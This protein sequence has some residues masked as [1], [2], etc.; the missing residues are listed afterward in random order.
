[1]MNQPDARC[2]SGYH[3]VRKIAIGLAG[4]K[5][6]VIL[7]FSVAYKVVV[8]LAGL[9][10]AAVSETIFHFLFVL[11]VTGLMLMAEVFNTVVESLCDYLEPELDA[12]IKNIKDMAAGATLIAILIWCVVLA[13]VLYEVLAGTDLFAGPRSRL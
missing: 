11:A 4:I 10:V 2:T 8:S 1:M 5:H 6:A 7:D 12:R 3:P 13:V 9:I